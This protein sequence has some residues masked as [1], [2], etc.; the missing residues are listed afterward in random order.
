MRPVILHGRAGVSIRLARRIGAETDLVVAPAGAH[1][2]ADR[3][4]VVGDDADLAMAVVGY[5]DRGCAAPA[6]ALTGPGAMTTLFAHDPGITAGLARLRHGTDYAC[7]LGRLT[8]A[9]RRVAFVGMVRAGAGARRDL[10]FPWCGRAGDVVVAGRR[11]LPVAHAR[12]VTAANAQRSG[13]WMLAPR[14]AAMDG[15]L[16]IQVFSGPSLALGRLRPA[17]RAGLHERSPRVRRTS[18]TAAEVTVPT[19][20]P[21]VAD[22]TMQGRGTFRVHAEIRAFRLIV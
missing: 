15:L 13:P 18:A 20:W 4:L 14:A 17:L 12:A 19:D 2:T 8:I 11:E 9:G 5:L 3:A 21:V 6:F 10:L 1:P 7:D 22:G 16:D